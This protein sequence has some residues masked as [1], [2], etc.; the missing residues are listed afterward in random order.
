MQSVDVMVI[1]SVEDI[2]M[3]PLL[4]DLIDTDRT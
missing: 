1:S 3:L 4:V 2:Y